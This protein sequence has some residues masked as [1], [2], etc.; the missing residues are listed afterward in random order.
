VET[1]WE[2]FLSGDDARAL[3]P[4][5]A[6]DVNRLPDVLVVGGG[7]LGLA[8]AVMCRRAGIDRVVVIERGRLAC[9]ASGKAAGGLTPEVHALG[10]PPAFVELARRGLALHQELDAA[11]DGD[12]GVRSLHWLI[13]VADSRYGPPPEALSAG[14]E[15]LDAA[16]ARAF[17]PNLGSVGG[18]L[19]IPEQA[20]VNPLRLAC[21]LASRA[22]EV[23]TGVAM[24]GVDR[25]GDKVIRV[26]TSIGDFSPGAVVFATGAVPSEVLSVPQ[27][28]V[29][30]HLLVTEPA[31]FELTAAVASTMLVI[32]LGD[33]RLLAGGTFDAGDTE[34]V[35]RDA[36]VDSIRAEMSELVPTAS[37][38]KVERAWCCFRPSTPD[39]LPIVDAVPGLGNAWVTAG[40]YRTGV[41]VAPAAG[42][43]LAAW[44]TGGARPKDVEAFALA[45]F[46]QT[47]STR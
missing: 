10:R 39:E 1:C 17:E 15:M 45:R 26:R 25:R 5:A 33:R 9:G 13:A 20:H 42:E 18:A 14:M 34:D 44:I 11:W 6:D 38:L 3:D 46:E 47:A 7:V 36:T 8:T 37:T 32:Q 35:V 27:G 41:L 31:P 29:K 22:G 23:A 28:S 4:G 16:G 21:A 43:A 12:A 19:L 40:H 30:G 2:S 24:T